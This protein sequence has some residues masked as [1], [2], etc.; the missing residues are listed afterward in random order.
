MHI[1]REWDNRVRLSVAQTPISQLGTSTLVE[2]VESWI[3]DVKLATA[4]ETSSADIWDSSA[5]NDLEISMNPT[6]AARK[7]SQ[8]KQAFRQSTVESEGMLESILF[9]EISWEGFQTLDD[10]VAS[11]LAAADILIRSFRFVSKSTSATSDAHS[12]R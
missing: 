1:R 8:K 6:H 10:M 5:P 2:D 7:P 12:S 11:P 4:Y 3:T 9:A